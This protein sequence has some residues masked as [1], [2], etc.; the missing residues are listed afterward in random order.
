MK[1]T[2]KKLHNDKG[3][4]LGA[5]VSAFPEKR[6]TPYEKTQIESKL[7]H[8]IFD[9]IYNSKPLHIYSEYHQDGAALVALL[10]INNLPSVE[11]T[12]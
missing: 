9:E 10:D 4:E 11:V 2:I 8:Y 12:I 6:I 3:V 5:I 7:Y 1:V